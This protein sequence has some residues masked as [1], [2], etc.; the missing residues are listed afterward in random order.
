MT[1]REE[2][3]SYLQ[4]RFDTKEI[5]DQDLDDILVA[6]SSSLL[7]QGPKDR[8]F[9]PPESLPDHWGLTLDSLDRQ[10]ENQSNYGLNKANALWRD[11][12]RKVL[13]GE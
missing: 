4:T 5:Y 6:I 2:L 11:M 9:I 8:E 12:I 1:L 7:E 13:G 10:I 3:K